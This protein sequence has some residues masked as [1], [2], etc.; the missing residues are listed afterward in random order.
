MRRGWPAGRPRALA[1]L[2][3]FLFSDAAPAW[4][5]ILFA[6]PCVALPTLLLGWAA[7]RLLPGLAG[8][9]IGGQVPV[10][11]SAVLVVVVSP[12]LE[13]L[14]MTGPVVLLDRWRG[15]TPAV[16]G[17]AL[18]WGIAHSLAAARWGL[19]IWWPFLLF[20]IA[21]LTWRGRGYWRAVGVV[22]A[23]HA[24]NNAAPIA[25]VLI[26]AA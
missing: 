26:G 7:F 8:P 6:W 25:V 16:I 9:A 23:L 13:T 12:F 10:W 4:R 14:L 3:R 2:P 18:L 17:S 24:L 11:L 20:S 19:A 5:Y 21:Y 22:F 15:P 1:F